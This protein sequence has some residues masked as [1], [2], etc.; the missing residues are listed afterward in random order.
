[1]NLT[2]LLPA[3]IGFAAAYE[4]YRYWKHHNRMLFEPLAGVIEREREALVGLAI[5]EGKNSSR[6]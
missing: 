3:D 2:Q 1:M 4:A 5:A 6:T